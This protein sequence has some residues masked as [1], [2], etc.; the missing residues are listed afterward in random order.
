MKLFKFTVI[1]TYRI[2]W[3]NEALHRRQI[4]QRTQLLCAGHTARSACDRL[5]TFRVRRMLDQCRQCV[6]ARDVDVGE[7][8]RVAQS[9]VQERGRCLCFAYVDIGDMEEYCNAFTFLLY[10]STTNS[11]GVNVH[12]KLTIG[13]TALLSLRQ[14]TSFF[15]SKRPSS[16][17]SN[18]CFD[19]HS[20]YMCLR[21]ES[22][23]ESSC[24]SNKQKRSHLS[25]EFLVQFLDAAAVC[26]SIQSLHC[27]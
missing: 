5:K 18:A 17:S 1:V 21:C 11:Q 20:A 3:T 15:S 7:I 27:L 25:S 24:E 23:K 22:R 13:A 14:L 6:G 2:F 19:K 8:W 12:G 26:L 10:H 9:S 16:N 4:G